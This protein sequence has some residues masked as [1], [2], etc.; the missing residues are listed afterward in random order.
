M[1]VCFALW[2]EGEYGCGVEG[3]ALV[4]GSDVKMLA[5]DATCGASDADWE[6][7]E[8]GLALGG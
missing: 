6:A 3:V 4:L 8:D 1:T 2:E 5:S 7:G